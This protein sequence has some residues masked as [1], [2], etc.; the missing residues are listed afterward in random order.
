MPRGET[1]ALRGFHGGSLPPPPPLREKLEL[2]QE[3][4]QA[5]LV[6]SAVQGG[7]AGLL[8]FLLLA[9]YLNRQKGTQEYIRVPRSLH[10]F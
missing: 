4:F 3:L 8:Q 5:G 10:N 2:K 1:E 7:Q 9:L 6:A